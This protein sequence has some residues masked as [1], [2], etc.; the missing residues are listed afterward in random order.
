MSPYAQPY[1]DAEDYNLESAKR[2]SAN[3]AGLCTWTQAMAAFFHINKE[4]L[5]LKANLAVAEAKLEKANAELAEAQ[6]K[7]DVAQVSINNKNSG[8]PFILQRFFA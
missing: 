5:P 7:L 4:V 1:F 6:G 8:G 3:V 2:V